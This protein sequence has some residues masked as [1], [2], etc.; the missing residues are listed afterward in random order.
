MNLKFRIWYLPEQ[1]MYYAGYQK[2]FSVLLCDDDHGANQ[3]RGIPVKDVSYDDCEFLQATD[4]LDHR[5]Q[6]IYEGDRVRILAKGR[7]Y[8]GIVET[9]PDMYRSRGLHPL[10]ELFEQLGVPLDAE[11]TFEILGNR[12]EVIRG[13]HT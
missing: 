4:I 13:H 6:E 2:I 12:Y 5:G 7:A 10:Q 8:E 1:K 9:V 3:G 11:M